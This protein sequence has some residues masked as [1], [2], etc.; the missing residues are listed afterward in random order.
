MLGAKSAIVASHD[1]ANTPD[2]DMSERTGGAAAA[3]TR[4]LVT[5]LRRPQ[6]LLIFMQKKSAE[7]PA[8]R[9]AAPGPKIGGNQVKPSTANQS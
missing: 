6:T 9:R 7:F 2:R 4:G 1:P 5:F 3:E 8:W